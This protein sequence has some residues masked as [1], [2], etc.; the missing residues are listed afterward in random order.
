MNKIKEYDIDQLICCFNN[1]KIQ[2]FVNYKIFEITDKIFIQ[3]PDSFIE[4]SYDYLKRGYGTIYRPHC[5][6]VDEKSEVKM[7]L[8]ILKKE[9]KQVE[10]IINNLKETIKLNN[11]AVI[12]YDYGEIFSSDALVTWIDYKTF[13]QNEIVYNMLFIT[14]IDDMMMIGIFNCIFC[15]YSQWKEVFLSMLQTISKRRM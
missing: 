1:R 11:N 6:L 9:E 10:E 4:A 3:I 2:Q 15:L 5:I 14:D 13:L 8:Q 7:S 12:F